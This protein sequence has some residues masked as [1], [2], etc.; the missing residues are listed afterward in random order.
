MKRIKTQLT[1]K[2]EYREENIEKFKEY[3]TEYYE[4]NKDTIKEKA[5]YIGN[6]MKK[7]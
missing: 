5:K 7:R 1:K 6:K 2:K 4:N 3:S